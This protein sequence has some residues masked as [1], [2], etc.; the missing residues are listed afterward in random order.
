MVQRRRFTSPAIARKCVANALPNVKS[1]TRNI[2]N[3]AL[4]LVRN[5]LK[6]AKKWP[7]NTRINNEPKVIGKYG[8]KDGAGEGNRTLVNIPYGP[9]G[10]VGGSQLFSLPGDFDP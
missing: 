2:A 6:S 3:V 4:R 1:M 10:F 8:G 5:A 7:C 9:N